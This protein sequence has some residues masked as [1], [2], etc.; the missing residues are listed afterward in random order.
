MNLLNRDF[1]HQRK[2]I[3]QDEFGQPVEAW[4]SLGTVKGRLRQASV[5]EKVVAA[6]VPALFYEYVFYCPATVDLRPEDRV[7]YGNLT[8]DI[9]GVDN[10]DLMNHH[11]EAKGKLVIP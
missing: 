7:V 3:T 8:V 6:Q 2:T 9:I 10:P 11:L 1:T 4:V 5:E